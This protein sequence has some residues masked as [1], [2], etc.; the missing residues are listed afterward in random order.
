MWCV[1]LL[2]SRI[3][4]SRNR[5]YRSL[6]LALPPAI[7]FVTFGDFKEFTLFIV[8][9]SSLIYYGKRPGVSGAPAASSC[10]SK[11]GRSTSTNFFNLAKTGLNSDSARLYCSI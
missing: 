7:I 8:H 9:P 4:I 11:A 3:L 6:S 5:G 2:Q 1:R 10:F